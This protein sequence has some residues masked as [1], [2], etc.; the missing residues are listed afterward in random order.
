MIPFQ[1]VKTKPRLS[2]DGCWLDLLK[3]NVISWEN[4]AEYSSVVGGAGPAGPRR[5]FKIVAYGHK[6]FHN[7]T[8]KTAKKQPGPG[9][10]PGILLPYP[11][12]LSRCIRLKVAVRPDL[13]LAWPQW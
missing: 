9:N 3:G 5:K 10:R 2:M 12:S 1:P 6:S 13:R 7:H 4:E 11:G 8:K